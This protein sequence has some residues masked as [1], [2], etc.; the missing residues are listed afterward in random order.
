MIDHVYDLGSRCLQGTGRGNRSVVGCIFLVNL[1]S[2]AVALAGHIALQSNSRADSTGRVR[3]RGC[4]AAHGWCR[5]AGS[6]RHRSPDGRAMAFLGPLGFV[7]LSH[8]VLPG[9]PVLRHPKAG[10]SILPFS[11]VGNGLDRRDRIQPRRT[12]RKV[13]RGRRV[14]SNQAGRGRS[15][16]VGSFSR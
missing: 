5:I 7:F 10:L 14:R 12:A 11:C 6:R 3:L 8:S 15:W 4:V 16:V 2:I 1:P 13:S 9:D